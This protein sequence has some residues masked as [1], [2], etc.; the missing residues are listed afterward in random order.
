MPPTS[1]RSC[2]AR[3]RSADRTDLR[4]AGGDASLAAFSDFKRDPSVIEVLKQ[5]HTLTGMVVKLCP[6]SSPQKMIQFGAR[7]AAFCRQVVADAGSCPICLQIQAHLFQQ[8][9]VKLKA[10]QLCCPAGIVHL[11]VP[12]LLAGRHIATIVGGKVRLRLPSPA[13]FAYC[14]RQLGLAADN[15]RLRLL[16][17]AFFTTPALTQQELS[18][19]VKLLQSLAQFFVLALKQ[20]GARGGA[21]PESARISAAKRFVRL[22]L[23]ET[24]TNGQAAQAAGVTDS[25]FCRL[26]HQSTG[27]TFRDYLATERVEQA[28]YELAHT[29][30]PISEIALAVGFQSIPDFNRVFKRKTKLSPSQYRRNDFRNVTAAPTT[31]LR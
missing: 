24:L 9:D 7:D 10:Q 2:H 19:A 26:F 28:K 13:R 11:A 3:R 29:L 31:A 23:A 14:C 15:G 21:N 27:L 25:Y 1:K 17:R 12:V 20:Q 6:P 4:V 18:A 30:K 16:R 5:F 8:L 22:H